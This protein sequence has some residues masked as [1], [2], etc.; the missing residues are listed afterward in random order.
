VLHQAYG[1]TRPI[2]TNGRD[3]R[4]TVVTENGTAWTC[5]QATVW[6]WREAYQH[7][8]AARMDW[9]VAN[10]FEKANHNPVAVFQG[11]R[12]KAV[13][14]MRAKSG[15]RVNLD[16]AGTSDPD[17]DKVSCRW[18]VYHEAG[19]LKGEVELQNST[20]P[21]AHFVAPSAAEPKSLHVILEVKDA[22]APPLYS[23]R[24]VIVTIEGK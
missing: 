14:Q 17:G 4:D 19:T 16:A 18:F 10:A 11:D 6:R 7:D 3:S 2:W 20:A 24:R 12:S 8:F 22:G 23:Y 1:E 5:D 15:A 9:C 13:V 21:E